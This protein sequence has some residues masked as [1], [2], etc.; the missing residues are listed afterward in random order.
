LLLPSS[1][2][3][4]PKFRTHTASLRAT[5]GF[6]LIRLPRI[7][8]TIVLFAFSSSRRTLSTTQSS[9]KGEQ[10]VLACV[11]GASGYVGSAIALRFL[12]LGHS[13]RLPVR[14]STQGEAWLKHYGDKYPGRITAI[15]LRSD[16]TERGAYD[17]TL[18]G[19]DVVV[20]A[21]SPTRL[22]INVR[23]LPAIDLCPLS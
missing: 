21:A 23:P 12:E 5:G 22:V 8:S 2:G 14:K 17:E 1:S 9:K 3:R 20:H 16:I 19:C 6:G 7:D 10:K 15:T 11:T 4:I 13:V 18:E